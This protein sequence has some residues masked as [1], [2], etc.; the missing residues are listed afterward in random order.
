MR[1]GGGEHG[2]CLCYQIGFYEILVSKSLHYQLQLHVGNAEKQTVAN[3]K[4]AMKLQVAD[5]T[6]STWYI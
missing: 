1:K 5:F 2:N 3:T 4:K 6:T